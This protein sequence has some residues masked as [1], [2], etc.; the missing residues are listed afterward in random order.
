MVQ[1][2]HKDQAALRER[3]LREAV[4]PVA[5]ELRLVDVADFVAYIHAGQFANIQDIV[6]SS[7]EL[8]FKPGTLSFGGG[9]EV[10]I[11]WDISPSMALDM[12]FRHHGVWAVFKLIMH[13]RET[14]VVIEHLSF[15]P[16]SGRA[17]IDTKRMVAALADARVLSRNH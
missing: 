6:H 5:D 16:A 4:A 11:G 12:E 13:G 14:A 8:L 15:A 7:V 17:A 2:S 9:A 1:S 3:A 10:E